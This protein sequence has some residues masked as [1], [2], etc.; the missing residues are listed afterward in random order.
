MS[1]E[2]T[3]I[4]RVKWS[5]SSKNSQARHYDRVAYKDNA[6]TLLNY[7][8]FIMRHSVKTALLPLLLLC[9][10]AQAQNISLDYDCD[11]PAGHYSSLDLD[12][13]DGDFAMEALVSQLEARRSGSYRPIAT[14]F[15]IGSNDSEATGLF[16]GAGDEGTGEVEFILRNEAKYGRGKSLGFSRSDGKDIQAVMEYSAGVLEISL[17]DLQVSEFV[18]FKP[19]ELRIG[20]SGGN[21]EFKNLILHFTQAQK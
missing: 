12:L 9:E 16:F 5:E 14:L 3:T 6:V 11:T 7:K 4:E 17:G 20:C 1:I 18:N 13:H 10:V 19:R 21:Y 8:G 2:S 15:L